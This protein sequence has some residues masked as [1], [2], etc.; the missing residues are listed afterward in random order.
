MSRRSAIALAALAGLLVLALATAA[1]ASA[2][3]HTC[4]KSDSYT[5][6]WEVQGSG[7][8]SP[9]EG[10]TV[11]E[12]R[13]IVTLDAQSEGPQ[14]RDGFFV[15]AHE[16]D[17]EEAT[18]DGL[19]VYTG[20]GSVSVEPGD[21]VAVEGATASEFEGPYW[22]DW[23][24][25]ETQLDCR[26]GCEVRL[27]EDQR[28][29]PAAQAWDPPAEEADARAYAE[30]REGAYVAFEQPATA[31]GPTDAHETAPVVP[32]ADRVRPVP[33]NGPHGDIARVDGGSMPATS[34]ATVGLP[35]LSTFDE[36]DHD[37][38]EGVG[39]QG[40]VGFEWALYTIVQDATARCPTPTDEPAPYAPA[41]NPIPAGPASR[42]TAATFNLYNLF[43][44][45]DDPHKGDPVPSEDTYE[46]K[47]AKHA[48]AICQ[49]DVLDA[50]DLIAVQ[51]V[52]NAKALDDVAEAVHQ[53]CGA[54]YETRT[55]T[56][57]DFRGIQAGL[58]ARA[59]NATI[60][61]AGPEQ[62]CS[63]TDHH[64]RYENGTPS[65]TCP[66]GQHFLFN[67]PPLM[68]ELRVEDAWGTPRVHVIVNHF[69]SKL[70]SST[71]QAADCSDW[72][73]DQADHVRGLAEDLVGE[74]SDARVLV[75]G[76]LNAG[77]DEPA[78]DELTGSDALASLWARVEG[79]PADEQGD[80]DR[81]T[82]VH[83]GVSSA[84]DH[85]LA[86]PSVFDD[87]VDLYPRHVNADRP[88]AD[89]EDPDTARG[90]SDHDPVLATVEL[91][92]PPDPPNA[93]FSAS[94]EGLACTFEASNSTD[95]HGE[96]LAYGWTLGDGTSAE[97][98]RVVHEYEETGRYEVTLTVED[99]LG[100]RDTAEGTV[101]PC[102]IP[103][104]APFTTV[105][106]VRS[107]GCLT[108]ATFG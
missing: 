68:A 62:G 63:P 12:L 58:M 19:F 85:V 80:I 81:Y 42:L 93:S 67:R 100:R 22:A 87:G 72:R 96:G 74:D 52:E 69:K 47:L 108:L 6:T 83:E 26:D 23:G 15:Q 107:M 20:F 37:P 77:V 29:R 99:A 75:L 70:S 7:E 1:P 21:L 84:L 4:S 94:C 91:P 82:Y 49:E 73:V 60:V 97:G 57:P 92:Q 105:R 24:G 59:S 61:E 8:R 76:D 56:A 106:L 9:L 53:R 5:A 39:V 89:E 3:E 95:P 66:E 10:E 27:I 36:I 25:S 65:V 16:P 40:P 104:E 44:P 79:P 30:A 33:D 101:E 90:S 46:R 17:C 28:G 11:D 102:R 34:C 35:E 48:R 45:H 18:S 14:P 86:T 78:L 43:D 38:D 50:P 51:E 88:A 55:R 54:D 2:T 98:V 103:D 31:V 71:C 32:G 41:E 13:A 64:I